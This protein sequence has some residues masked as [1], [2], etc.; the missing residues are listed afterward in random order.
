MVEEGYDVRA[1]AGVL[2]PAAPLAD[3]QMVSVTST[4]A[5]D[6]NTSKLR[7]C[8]MAVWGWVGGD[9][10]WAR[11]AHRGSIGTTGLN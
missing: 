7:V 5:A 1:S 10:Q 2:P 9:G 8:V 11:A 4:S 3:C 6:A